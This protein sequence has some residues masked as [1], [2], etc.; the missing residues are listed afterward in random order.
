MPGL[1]APEL[2]LKVVV[3][4]KGL[5]ELVML[6]LIGQA[7]LWL[8]AGRSRHTNP[9]Y[10]AFNIVGAR[11]IRMCRRITPSLVSDRRIPLVAAF[12]LLLIELLLIAAKI[13]LVFGLA[14]TPGT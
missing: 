3:L 12:W 1:D 2:A 4:L 10:G 14:V 6:T 5:N 13:Y 9:V 7:A 8:L 11:V